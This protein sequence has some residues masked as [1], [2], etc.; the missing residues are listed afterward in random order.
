MQLFLLL[1][2]SV[3]LFVSAFLTKKRFGLLGLAL[4]AGSVLA[5]IWSYEAGLTVGALGLQTNQMTSVVASSLLVLLPAGVLMTRGDH[6]KS[7]FGRVVGAGLFTALALAFLLEYI[8]KVL[9]V[10]GFGSNVYQWFLDNRL[11]IIGVGLVIA[12]VDIFMKKPTHIPGKHHK[13]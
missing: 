12:V 9:V 8:D 3:G 13:H 5:G 2:I 4:A 7:L 6:Y 1:A 10:N 11:M